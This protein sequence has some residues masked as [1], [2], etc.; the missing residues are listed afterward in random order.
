MKEWRN[1]SKNFA[2]KQR[3]SLGQK[4]VACIMIP[5]QCNESKDKI[6][7]IF[8]YHPNLPIVLGFNEWGTGAIQITVYYTFRILWEAY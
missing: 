6:G 2:L 7:D 1:L 3:V 8:K 4:P 5:H